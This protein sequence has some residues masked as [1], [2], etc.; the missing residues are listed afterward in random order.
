MKQ[1]DN[2][3][4]SKTNSNTRDPKTCTEEELS[5]NEFQKTKWFFKMINDFKEETQNLV[6]YLKEDVE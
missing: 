3:S 2:H 5:N 6:F 1:Q 4:Q